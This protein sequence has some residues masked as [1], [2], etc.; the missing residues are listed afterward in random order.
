MRLFIAIDIGAMDR[1][2]K[3]EKE[4][5]QTGANIKMVEPSNIHCTL[6]FLGEVDKHRIDAIYDS[7]N[8]AVKDISTFTMAVK[9]MGVFPS[10]DYIKVIWV[11]LEGGLII[12]IAEQLEIELSQLGFKKEKRIYTSH[13]T[14]ARV[15]SAQAKE[16]LLEVV[17]R[18]QNTDFGN[19]L[20]K[21]ICLKKSELEPK[22]PVYT[23]LREISL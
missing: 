13:S 3:V 4:L 6:K 20:V 21:T 22:G 9:G 1:L 14:L 8:R 23:T 15:K 5:E 17:K 16:Q 10:L 12:T 11:G 19:K 18:H 2:V 7:M